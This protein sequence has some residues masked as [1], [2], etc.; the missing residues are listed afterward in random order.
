MSLFGQLVPAELLLKS[1]LKRL[2]F[3]RTVVAGI[4]AGLADSVR[5]LYGG[6]VKPDNA[7]GLMAQVILMALGWW[8]KPEG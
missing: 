5:I 8:S 3:V 4:D 6:S 7:A 1:K 2:T